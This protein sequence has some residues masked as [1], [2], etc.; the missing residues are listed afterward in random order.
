M[1]IDTEIEFYEKRLNE[2]IAA[3]YDTPWYKIFKRADLNE[4]IK[5]Y[6]TK[7]DNLKAYKKWQ[8]ND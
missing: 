6:A 7:V 3:W 2:S 4:D 5:R 1:N 8:K